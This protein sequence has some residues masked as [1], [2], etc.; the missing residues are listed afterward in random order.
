L[1]TRRRK[2]TFS[3]DDELLSGLDDA[4]RQG[5]ATSKNQLVAQALS[6]E[7]K[8]LRRQA[9]RAQLEEALTD[10]LFLRDVDD[11]EDAFG[12]ADAETARRIA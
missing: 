12:E 9:E 8:E 1:A 11:M 7:L 4:V 3:L 5:M 6:K 2:A 10:P